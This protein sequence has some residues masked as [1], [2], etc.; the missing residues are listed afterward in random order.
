MLS[1]SQGPSTEDPG[2]T[3]ASAASTQAADVDTDEPDATD[4]NAQPSDAASGRPSLGV[5]QRPLLRVRSLVDLLALVPV[6]LGFEPQESL[7][8]VALDGAHPGFQLRVDLPEPAAADAEAES[9]A[10]QVAAAVRR[11]AC[12]R[13][14]VIIFT[15]RGEGAEPVATVAARHLERAGVELLD[16]L[17][18]DGRRYWSLLCGDAACCPSTG[19]PYDPRTSALRAEATLAGRTVVPDRAALAARFAVVTGSERAAARSA[20][21]QV[22]D[23]VVA[24]LG[25]QA[26]S[27]VYQLSG[28]PAQVAAPLGARRVDSILD[29]LLPDCPTPTE[30]P[31]E[32]PVSAS[33]AATLAVWCALTPVR[34]V[35]WARMTRAD[36]HRHLR[37]WTAVA[38]RTLPPYEPAVLGLAAFAAW[39]CGDGAS[40]W[41]AVDRCLHADPDYPMAELLQSALHRCVPPDSWSPP[42]RHLV[43]AA[44]G[45]PGG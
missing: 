19:T 41:C 17:R 14:A 42:P 21:D 34:D 10:E 43:W 7:V 1:S 44:C 40:A 36:A 5:R 22:E 24:L 11:Q 12:S 27:Q 30:A 33:D 8:V 20:L 4:P 45:L 16:V 18:T 37:L 6:T 25:L 26:R 2:S 31:I 23:D 32:V 13:A 35:A 39:L 29:A 15:Q 3:P 28:K 38:R 9:L